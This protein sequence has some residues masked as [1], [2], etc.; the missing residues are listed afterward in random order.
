[1]YHEKRGN[2]N[3][4]FEV[5]FSLLFSILEKFV[6]QHRMK[7]RKEIRGKVGHKPLGAVLRQRGRREGGA[8]ALGLEVGQG[9]LHEEQRGG[10]VDVHLPRPVR[11][12][13]RW[14]GLLLRR[15]G[16]RGWGGTGRT[17][18]TGPTTG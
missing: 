13:Q 12:L 9:V 6:F 18:W 16:R 4:F 8:C 7:R 11:A 1:M 5:V 3:T 14:R 17:R 2:T 10:H 15:R